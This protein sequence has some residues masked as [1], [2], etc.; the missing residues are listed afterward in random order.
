MALRGEVETSSISKLEILS[1][2]GGKKISLLGGTDH[3]FK[4]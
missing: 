1:N 2:Q 4:Q 3:L